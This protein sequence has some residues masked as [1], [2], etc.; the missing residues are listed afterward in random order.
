MRLI[1]FILGASTLLFST[2]YATPNLVM[3]LNKINFQIDRAEIF[4]ANCAV[5]AKESQTINFNCS[6]ASEILK[7]LN[8]KLDQVEELNIMTPTFQTTKI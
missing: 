7:K 8:R 6:Q 5:E 4:A 1:T 2:S 3:K